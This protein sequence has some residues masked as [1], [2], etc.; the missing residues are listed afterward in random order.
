MR[1]TEAIQLTEAPLP[2]D[3]DREKFSPRTSYKA[4]VS[5]AK[6]RAE[7]IGRGS[8]RVAF[9]VPYQ[10]R[11][12]V[13]KVA[14]NSKGIAQNQEEAMLLEDVYV[15][16]TGIVIPLIDYDEENGDRIS[17]IHTEYAEKVTQKNLERYFDGVD[18]HTI[19]MYLDMLQGRNRMSVSIPESLH[20]NENFAALQDLVLNVGLPAGDF[21]RKA[22]WGIYR[23][24]PV[25]IDIGYTDAVVPLYQR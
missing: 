5:Y 16:N 1:L 23:G 19:T 17:W 22:N 6:S 25:I 4:M 15:S 14:L 3:W 10:G 2:P 7:Q 9:V 21:S 8:S 12:T 11:K 18:M 20:D 24:E 13:I